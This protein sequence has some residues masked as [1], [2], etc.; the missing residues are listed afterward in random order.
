VRHGQAGGARATRRGRAGA[1][2]GGGAAGLRRTRRCGLR[3]CRGRTVQGH[4]DR[5]GAPRPRR[6]GAAPSRAP[7]PRARHAGPPWSRTGAALRRDGGPRASQGV[8]RV[9]S[10][11]RREVGEEGRRRG[12]PRGTRAA[13]T[14]GGRAR[15]SSVIVETAICVRERW[16]RPCGD[17][18]R[19][20]GRGAGGAARAG[21]RECGWRRGEID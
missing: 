11:G 13:W 15:R 3:P 10:M 21:G 4:H 16:P 12:S 19:A 5:A 17:A 7:Q 1:S 20:D 6:A 9:V 18:A 2:A 14:D 8:A